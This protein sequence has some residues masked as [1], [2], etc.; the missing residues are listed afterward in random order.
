MARRGPLTCPTVESEVLWAGAGEVVAGLGRWLAVASPTGWTASGLGTSAPP[1]ARRLAPTSLEELDLDRLLATVDDSDGGEPLAVV[2][3]GGGLALD[4]AKYVAWRT[5]WPLVLVP[6]ALGSLAPFTGEVARRVRR[7]QVWT[8]R[9]PAP[10][11]CSTRPCW[12]PLRPPSTGPGPPRSSPPCRP[13]GT[14]AW[15]TPGT[16]GCRSRRRWPTS[17]T[18]CRAELAEA[19]PAIAAGSVEGLRSLAGLLHSLGEACARVGHR[20]L[21]DGSE[22]TFVQAYEHRLGH[23]PSYGGLLGVGTVAMATLQQWYGVSAGGSGRPGRGRRAA[24]RRRRWPPTPTS[25]GWTRARSGACCATPFASTWVSSCP[26]GSS[27]RP[28]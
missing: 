15:P 6:T 4:T 18:G 9:G 12:P 17:G 28:T 11:W 22:H 19:A 23:L 27:T 16:R 7:Q 25:S 20:R 10:A 13:P 21:V 5:G 1:P 24:H 26:G 2:G 3:V 8:G 14:G